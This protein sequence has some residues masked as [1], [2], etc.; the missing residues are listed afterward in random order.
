MGAMNM[1]SG[2]GGSSVHVGVSSISGGQKIVKAQGIVNKPVNA[3]NQN[4]G[5]G[6]GSSYSTKGK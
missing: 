4:P 1:K 5:Y 2:T 3:H 6:K